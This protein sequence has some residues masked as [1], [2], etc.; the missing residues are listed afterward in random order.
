MPNELEAIC[1]LMR[2]C[3]EVI[4]GADR[5][6][7]RVDAK[8]GPADFVTDYDKKVQDMLQRG[9][10]GIVP[11]AHF[12]GEEGLTLPFSSEGKFFIVD[13]IDGTTNFIKNLHASAISV[14][15]S[16]DGIVELG[17]IYN[18]YLDELF[19]ARRGR[20]AFCN[21]RPIHVSSE[22]LENGIVIFG[23]SP[24]NEEVSEKSFRLAYEYHRRA[25]DVRRTG[26]AAID[27]C[28]IAAGRAE[29]FFELM[30]SPWDYAAGALIVEEA[31]GIVTDVDG[32]ALSL[33]RKCS[34]V[35]RNAVVQPL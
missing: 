1:S 7:I 35:A 14:A 10:A 22:P 23:T 5:E 25:L 21:G 31:G 24:Y 17:V 13:P 28:N 27:L 30:L 2:E 4:R 33:E 34:V 9:L 29:L 16:V 18:P 15:L 26:S 20:G 11:D 12:V 19:T 3:G 8:S 6:N 32:H